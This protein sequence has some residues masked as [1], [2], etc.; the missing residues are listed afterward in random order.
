[1]QNQEQL[2]KYIIWIFI[3]LLLFKPSLIL[4]VIFGILFLI[5][6]FLAIKE[7][8]KKKGINLNFSGMKDGKQYFSVDNTNQF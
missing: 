1:M 4:W 3:C 8:S 2:S 5:P 7:E 6:I